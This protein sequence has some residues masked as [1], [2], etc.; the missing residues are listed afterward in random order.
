MA[1]RVDNYATFVA[2]DPVLKKASCSF[3]SYRDEDGNLRYISQTT[4]PRTGQVVVYKFKFNRD[5]RFITVPLNKKDVNGNSFVDF[6][7]NH[8]RNANSPIALNNPWFKEVD[9][10]RDAE[11]AIS[12]VK[13][14]NEAE[15]KALNLKDKEFDEVVKVLGYTGDKNVKLHK[16]LQY[17]TRNPSDFLSIVSDP[18]R[19]ARSLFEAALSNKVITRH[20]FRFVYGDTHI[21]ND[22]DKAIIKIA[23]DKDLQEILENALK[24][25]GA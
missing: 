11:V 7:R 13:L 2:L 22:K 25:A 15:N 24:K 10:G 16:V 3:G 9:N 17:A 12:S 6:L 18:N 19:K 20:G 1:K 4:D 14:R 8:P 21:A 23:E 5:K